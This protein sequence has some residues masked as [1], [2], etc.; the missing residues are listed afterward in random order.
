MVHFSEIKILYAGN[1]IWEYRS[2]KAIDR[3]DV[4]VIKF[5]IMLVD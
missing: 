4:K 2:R 3:K 1:S 5:M